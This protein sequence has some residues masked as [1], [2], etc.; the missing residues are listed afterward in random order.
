MF[1]GF[2]YSLNVEHL[3]LDRSMFFVEF[4]FTHGSIVD[5]TPFAFQKKTKMPASS[6]LLNEPDLSGESGTIFSLG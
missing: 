3:R 2:S 4:P 6:F 5:L 1:S